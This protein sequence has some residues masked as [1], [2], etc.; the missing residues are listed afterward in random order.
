MTQRDDDV[1]NALIA[2]S[3]DKDSDE[4]NR[5]VTASD[6]SLAWIAACLETLNLGKINADARNF[7]EERASD[8]VAA[9]TFARRK[10]HHGKV[11]H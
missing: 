3:N 1:A 10:S 7:L 4:F 11:K 9:I 5:E 2:V 6:V 8:L